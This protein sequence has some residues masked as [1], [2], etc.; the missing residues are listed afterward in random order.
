MIS[1][2]L[3]R[4]HQLD[5]SQL[6]NLWVGILKIDIYLITNNNSVNESCTIVDLILNNN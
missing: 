6:D 4:S 1:I 5:S 2:Q 3:Y